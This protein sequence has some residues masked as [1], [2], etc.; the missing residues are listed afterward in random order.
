M[1]I[2]AH[3]HASGPPRRPAGAALIDRRVF[4]QGRIIA[5]Y[6]KLPAAGHYRIFW[7]DAGTFDVNVKAARVAVYAAP[8]ASATAIEE[9]L[10]GSVCS[11]CL[12]EHG[13]E[14]LHAS[15]ILWRGRCLAFA[16]PSGSGKSSLAAFLS[17]NG[18]TFLADDVLPLRFRGSHVL[19]HSGLPQMRLAGRA[20][21]ELGLL[22]RDFPEEKKTFPVRPTNPR[23]RPVQ[24][25]YL[26][27]RRAPG[28]SA[29][30]VQRLSAPQAF[31]ALLA[32]SANWS[33]TAPWRLENQMRTLGWLAENVPVHQ[34]QYPSRFSVWKDIAAIL[35]RA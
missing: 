31:A 17:R 23:P 32:H 1:R 27:H 15:A 12:L 10:R 20:A 13:F 8:K 35:L 25:V 16:G 24:A 33:Q 5:E 19:A 4:S 22:P 2:R 11:F 28:R 21:R 30:A 14:P 3:G 7:S 29:F 6:W 9:V 26:L 34:L 18:A